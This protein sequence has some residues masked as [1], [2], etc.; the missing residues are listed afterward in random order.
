VLAYINSKGA[1]RPASGPAAAAKPAAA[2]PA[3]KA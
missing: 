3:A 1:V 2:A